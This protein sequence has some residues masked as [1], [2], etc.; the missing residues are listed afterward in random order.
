ISARGTLIAHRE[1]NVLIITDAA[2][3]IRRL[4][5]IIRL[6]DVQV[7]PEELQIIPI[8]FADAADLANI[9][10]QL[11]ASRRTRT[12]APGP[13]SV[14]GPRRPPRRLPALALPLSHRHPHRPYPARRPP[15][16]C[17]ASARRAWPR[18]R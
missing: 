1:T 7:A 5:D 8:K 14:P 9:L 10:N 11:F 2:S 16:A 4:L 12:V 18:A 6:V 3:N 15:S 17:P 13:P